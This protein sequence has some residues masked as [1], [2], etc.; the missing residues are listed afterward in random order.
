MKPSVQANIPREYFYQKLLKSDSVLPSY[1]WWNTGVCFSDSR[2]ICEI[3]HF[4]AFFRHCGFLIGCNTVTA[5]VKI[6]VQRIARNWVFLITVWRSD[7]FIVG[8]TDVDPRESAPTLWDYTVCGQYP[9]NATAE[10]T[11]SVY[12]HPDTPPFRYVI[13]QFPTTFELLTICEV[14]VFA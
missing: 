4:L 2:C 7:K 6:N 12:C 8:L 9:G 13:L 1:G 5:V 11:L 3:W 14:E 10:A